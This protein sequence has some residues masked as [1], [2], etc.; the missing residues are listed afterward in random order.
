[1]LAVAV[2]G[3]DRGVWSTACWIPGQKG[4]RFTEVAW[5]TKHGDR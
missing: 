5:M 2:E 4:S 3:D 1:M